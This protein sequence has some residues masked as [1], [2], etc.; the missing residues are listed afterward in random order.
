[1]LRMIPLSLVGGKSIFHYC[2]L[3]T[4]A[5]FVAGVKDNSEVTGI[6]ELTFHVKL[7]WTQMQRLTIRPFNTEQDQP[8]IA[9][10]GC[11]TRRC[12]QEL[13]ITSNG[14]KIPEENLGG[15]S[16][17]SFRFCPEHRIVSTNTWQHPNTG[18]DLE[19]SEPHLGFFVV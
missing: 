2:A 10:L 9:A 3:I 4:Q 17:P 1:M 14:W 18:A 19:S 8:G 16:F 7:V 12:K 6:L 5:V 13:V 11:L 15:S